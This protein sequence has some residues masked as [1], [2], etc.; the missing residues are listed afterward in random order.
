MDYINKQTGEVIDIKDKFNQE[1][2]RA[3]RIGSSLDLTQE[4]VVSLRTTT[5]TLTALQV[6][7]GIGTGIVLGKGIFTGACISIG[8]MVIY[9]MMTPTDLIYKKVLTFKNK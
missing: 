7:A 1:V 8:T 5:N 9:D 2:D 3:T 4:Q 6:A